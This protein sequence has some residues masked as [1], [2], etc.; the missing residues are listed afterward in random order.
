MKL[1]TILLLFGLIMLDGP[2]SATPAL[3]R[4]DMK[5]EDLGEE[6]EKTP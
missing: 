3:A 6:I 4:A 2:N 1:Q 5:I